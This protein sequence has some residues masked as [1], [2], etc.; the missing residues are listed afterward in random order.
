MEQELLLKNGYDLVYLTKCALREET[1]DPQRIEA[2]D[3]EAVHAL[4]LRHSMTAVS[5]Y[6]VESY[7]KSYEDSPAAQHPVV[8][9]WLQEKLMAIRKNLLLDMER[10]NILSH[11]EK[12]GCWYMPLK[13]V[14][15]QELYP[16]AGMRQMSDN[17]ILIDPAFRMAVAEFM[18][19]RGYEADHI[20]MYIH[21]EFLKKPVYNFEIHVELL[22]KQDGF[23]AEYYR[24]VKD[25]LIKDE[26]NSFGYHFTDEDFY[27]FMTVHAAKHYGGKGN[28]IRSL[29]DAFVYSQQKGSALDRQYIDLELATLSLTEYEQAIVQ[30]ADK[31]FGPGQPLSKEEE[32]LFLY[33]VSCGTYGN[34]STRIDNALKSIA[35]EKER[36]TFWVKVKYSL[37]RLFPPVEFYQR[38]APLAY[39]YK[40]LIP[41]VAIYRMTSRMIFSA[42]R[43]WGEAKQAWS[44]KGRE[45]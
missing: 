26:Q 1:P 24:Q 35:G 17:D 44:K 30:L 37:R 32:A 29:M 11:L 34:W 6:A 45:S 33:H 28:G 21:D 31:L 3:L 7:R 13:G 36:I 22:S 20:G 4:A 27:L 23:W 10:E 40:V 18:L 2:M 8:E 38:Y 15:L 9:I 16:R 5:A 43:F 12:I 39:R 41:F 42:P 25:R 19:D 14:F